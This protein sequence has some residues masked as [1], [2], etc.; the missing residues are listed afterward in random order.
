MVITSTL[1]SDQR[2]IERPLSCESGLHRPPAIGP[3]RWNAR[4]FFAPHLGDPVARELRIWLEEHAAT[5][6]AAAEVATLALRPDAAR[7][8]EEPALDGVPEGAAAHQA[9]ASIRSG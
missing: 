4:G 7:A 5:T 6:V 3:S 2:A 9:D 1:P 8:R